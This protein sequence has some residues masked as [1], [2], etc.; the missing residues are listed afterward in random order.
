VQKSSVHL[1]TQAPGPHQTLQLPPLPLGLTLGVG[2]GPTQTPLSPPPQT[3]GPGLV[4]TTLALEEQPPHAG[5]QR[6]RFERGLPIQTQAPGTPRERQAGLHWV[7]G[8]MLGA[9]CRWVKARQRRAPTTPPTGVPTREDRPCKEPP[10]C[11]RAAG[12]R[13]SRCA[14]H[15]G[16]GQWWHPQGLQAQTWKVRL[17]LSPLEVRGSAWPPPPAQGQAGHHQSSQPPR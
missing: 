12:W 13:A 16:Q 11:R 3:H 7:P 9:Q 1:G 10:S 14:L 8:E 2:L 17:R 6:R 4:T 5:R 15:L